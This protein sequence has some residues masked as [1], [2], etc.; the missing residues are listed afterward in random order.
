MIFA[1]ASLR[2]S[3]GQFSHILAYKEMME[4]NQHEVV[5]LLHPD[6]KEFCRQEVSLKGYN[7]I[8]YISSPSD[9]RNLMVDAVLFY[10]TSLLDYFVIRNLRRNSC[11]LKAIYTYHEPWRG[12]SSWLRDLRKG[13]V[14]PLAVIKAYVM[15]SVAVAALRASDVVLLPSET[16]KEIYLQRDIRLNDHY[17]VL[18]L[19]YRD[20]A[21]GMPQSLDR[22]YFSFIATADKEKNFP[23]FLTC[24]SKYFAWDETFKAQIV[25]KTD[26]SGYWLHELDPYVKN[27][28]LRVVSGN[29]LSNEEINAALAQSYCT[30]LFYHHS[31]QS[32]VLARAFMMSCPV[33][34]SNRGCFEQY[35]DGN[36][37]ILISEDQDEEILIKRIWE[38]QKYIKNHEIEMVAR[39]RR[40]FESDFFYREYSFYFESLFSK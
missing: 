27:E 28:R 17:C 37:G 19:I 32:G 39:A 11:T 6:Y 13:R 8:Y 23:L 36:N 4:E 16:A 14:K 7:R 12:I 15:H 2:L 38:A 21:K 34:A 35:V 3:I 40:S 9:T 24:L 26:I 29:V 31:T 5:L 22:R 18:P 1:I 33:I 25:T 10:N 20:E 30:W